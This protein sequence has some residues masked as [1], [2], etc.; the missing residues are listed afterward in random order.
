MSIIIITLILGTGFYFSYKYFDIRSQ[1]ILKNKFALI[2]GIPLILIV[3]TSL[4]IG[5]SQNI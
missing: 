2:S 4:I 5:I 1:K 3:L